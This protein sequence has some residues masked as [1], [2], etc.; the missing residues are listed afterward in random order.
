[1]D[2]TSGRHRAGPV[3]AFDALR[4]RVRSGRRGDDGTV[5]EHRPGDRASIVRLDTA[6]QVVD[7]WCTRL[8]PQRPV[9]A[10]WVHGITDADVAHSPLFVDVA[11]QVARRL[12]GAVVVAHDARFDAGFIIRWLGTTPRALVRILGHSGS[13]VELVLH[14]GLETTD[15]RRRARLP[16][17]SSTVV[18]KG[19]D[20]T[21]APVRTI[22]GDRSGCWGR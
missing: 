19:G 17:S 12:D 15:R 3:F 9:G 1:M 2:E 11:D 22:S 16:T 14:P 10:S 18:G 20:S 7:E 21:R 8:N 4:S 6:G 13:V 5:R